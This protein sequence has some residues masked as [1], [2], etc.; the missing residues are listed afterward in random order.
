MKWDLGKRSRFVPST[1]S[2][3]G[4]L[5]KPS[6]AGGE[7]NHAVCVC[8]PVCATLQTISLLSHL[9]CARCIW[10]PHLI[11]VPTST[12]LNWEME[13]KR[14]APGFKVMTYYGSIKDRK[15]KRQVGPRHAL[16]VWDSCFVCALAASPPPAHPA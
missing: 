3:C 1:A 4:L 16:C 12:M 14:W 7:E 15:L 8:R 6:N 2:Q 13:F 10:G 11:V 5:T 9:A